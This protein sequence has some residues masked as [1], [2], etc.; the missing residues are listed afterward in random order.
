MVSPRM[1]DKSNC[2][3]RF[4]WTV[5]LIGYFKGLF[6]DSDDSYSQVSTIDES[7]GKLVETLKANNLYENTL[8]GEIL[9]VSCIKNLFDNID[10]WALAQGALKTN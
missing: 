9:F 6:G 3:G 7:V 8:I 10:F 2:F 1:S 5:S 4:L